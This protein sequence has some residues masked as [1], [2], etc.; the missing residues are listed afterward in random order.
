MAERNKKQSKMGF[1]ASA[2]LINF[3]VSLKERLK[4]C[5][6]ECEYLRQGNKFIRKC[7]FKKLVNAKNVMKFR[8]IL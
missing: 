6:Y 3:E 4:N 5:R 8:T 2:S 7:K 1:V